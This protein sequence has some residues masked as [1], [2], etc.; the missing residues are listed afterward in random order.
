MVSESVKVVN[1]HKSSIPS[2]FGLTIMGLLLFMT[3][4]MLLAVGVIEVFKVIE[5]LSTALY[6]IGGLFLYKAGGIVLR[7]CA[8]NRVKHERRNHLKL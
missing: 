3:G 6:L 2:K 8:T 5:H 1:Y 7:H 4:A